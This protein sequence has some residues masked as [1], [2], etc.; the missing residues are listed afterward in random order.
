LFQLFVG[1]EHT[2]RVETKSPGAFWA[3]LFYDY[4]G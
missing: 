2:D 4:Q 3:C 1:M